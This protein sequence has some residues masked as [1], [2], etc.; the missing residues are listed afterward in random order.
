MLP[1]VE[2]R[3]SAPYFHVMG[4]D[5]SYEG[6]RKNPKKDIEDSLKKFR[7]F[8]NK[9]AKFRSVFNRR[10]NKI[11]K[12][13]EKYSG[14]DWKGQYVPI[15]LVGIM[16]KPSFADPLTLKFREDVELML[17]LVI[18]ELTHVNLPSKMQWAAGVKKAEQWVNL[19]TRHV[20]MDLK[21]DLKKASMSN[22]DEALELGWDLRKKPLKKYL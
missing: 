2:V 5:F 3:L 18:H 20:A 1:K 4:D 10:R 12:L 8:E 13:I 6:Y 19:I 16:K 17:I 11:L 15:Y 7:K 22:F 21:L 14:Y 9:T